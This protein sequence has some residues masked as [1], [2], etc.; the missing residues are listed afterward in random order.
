MGAYLKR[1]MLPGYPILSFVGEPSS[2]VSAAEIAPLSVEAASLIDRAVIGTP[3]EI[4]HRFWA[5]EP[6]RT[7]ALVTRGDR[8]VGYYYV[9]GGT[10]GP[11]AWL[12][13]A[14]AELVLERALA[15]ALASSPQVR[16]RAL[17]INHAAIRF[18]LDRGL[19]LAGYSHLLTTAP[20][21]L[22]DRYVPSGPSLF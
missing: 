21:G 12:A 20:F 22:L 18:A 8:P 19:R 17:G 15:D 7:G 3:R 9:R 2:V 16:I 14:D 5:G 1:G 11:A 10:I 4:D 6:G 13:P